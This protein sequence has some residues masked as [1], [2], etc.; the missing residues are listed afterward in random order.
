MRRIF[1]DNGTAT[2]GNML[3][4]RDAGGWEYWYL[5]VNNDTPGTDD[6]L[7]PPTR[8]RHT[9]ATRCDS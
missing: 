1:V 6:G 3:V 9:S 7:N 4:L 2:Q 8:K 5:H